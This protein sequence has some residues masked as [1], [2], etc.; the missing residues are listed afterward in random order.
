MSKK[1]FPK[2]FSATLL[3]GKD[4]STNKPMQHITFSPLPKL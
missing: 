4:K 3:R 1:S 2:F